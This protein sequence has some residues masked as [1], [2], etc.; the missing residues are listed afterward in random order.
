[1]DVAA[2]ARA[3][4]RL[5]LAHGFRADLDCLAFAEEGE[6]LRVPVRSR[7]ARSA[8]AAGAGDV[9]RRDRFSPGL[10]PA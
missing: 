1:M 4:D 3:V 5:P 6:W 2:R 10:S 9:G 7:E 8:I